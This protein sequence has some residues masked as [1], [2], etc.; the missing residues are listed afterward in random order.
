MAE[1]TGDVVGRIPRNSAVFARLPMPPS[2]LCPLSGHRSPL[3]R[4]PCWQLTM[5]S[6]AEAIQRS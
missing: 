2:R 1:A 6:T 4:R 3:I 5:V